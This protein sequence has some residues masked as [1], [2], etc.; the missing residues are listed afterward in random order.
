M[1]GFIGIPDHAAFWLRGNLRAKVSASR[2]L[3]RRF[4]SG[5]RRSP[6]AARRRFFFKTLIFWWNVTSNCYIGEAVIFS[7]TGL[8]PPLNPTGLNAGSTV[9]GS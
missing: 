7:A 1:L 4:W 8:P 5:F 3:T 9:K 6:T 2:S